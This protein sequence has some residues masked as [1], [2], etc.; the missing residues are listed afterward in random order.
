[1]NEIKIYIASKITGEEETYKEKFAAKEKE[2]KEMG[3]VVMNPAVLPYPG[4]EHN[5]Y[6]HIC[7]AMIDVC[8][9]I[10]LFGDWKDSIGAN[11]EFAYAFEKDKGIWIEDWTTEMVKRLME[12][13]ADAGK[14]PRGLLE[15][16]ATESR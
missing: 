2:L 12:G 5:E 11:Q 6:M 10:L 3:Y 16:F 13:G 4:F 8:D 7:K 9:M 15:N 14:R 1:M